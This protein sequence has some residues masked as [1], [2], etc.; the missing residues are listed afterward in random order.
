MQIPVGI[1][2]AITQLEARVRDCLGQRSV[3]QVRGVCA[4]YLALYSSRA[5]EEGSHTAVAEH[6]KLLEAVVPGSFSHCKIALEHW[7]RCSGYMDADCLRNFSADGAACRGAK[8]P[9][10][11]AWA[12]VSCVNAHRLRYGDPGMMRVPDLLEHTRRAIDAH[13]EEFCVRPEHEVQ[14]LRNARFVLM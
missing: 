12:Q 14:Q 1:G 10:E 2:S 11:A 3:K 13:E 9:L 7:R 5:Q 8:H 4:G 6:L